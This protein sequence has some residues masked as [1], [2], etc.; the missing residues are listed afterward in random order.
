MW[1]P[2]CPNMPIPTFFMATYGRENYLRHEFR[3][4][5]TPTLTL[6]LRGRELVW[7]LFS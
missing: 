5:F 6:P 2:G 4:D 3:E 7:V 1:L